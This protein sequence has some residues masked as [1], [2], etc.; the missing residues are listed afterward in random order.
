ML[1][2]INS[3]NKIHYAAFLAALDKGWKVSPVAGNDNHGLWGI[4]HHTSRTFVLATRKTK[5]AILEAMQ[6][7]RTYASLEQNIQCQYTV[8]GA[9]MGS[10]LNRPTSFNFVI[11]VSDPDTIN[12]A[13]KITKI[14]IVKDGG[15]VTQTFSP[16]TAHTV[17]WNPTTNDATSKYFFVCVWN[18]GGGDARDAD[19]TKPVAWLAPVWTG[20]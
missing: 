18:A 15:V 16:T 10:T 20:R 19:P 5:A 2:V 7:R 1:E 3:N 12:P 17:T 11:S 9:I 14:D 6:H 13:D 8:N 4:T